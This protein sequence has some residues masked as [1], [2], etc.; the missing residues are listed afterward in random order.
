MQLNCYGLYGRGQSAVL[1]CWGLLT[2]RLSSMFPACAR[3]FYFGDPAFSISMF[4][5]SFGSTVDFAR[6]IEF[7]AW[8]E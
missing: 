8:A 6:L 1:L 7:V 2:K 3:L 5:H 4:C